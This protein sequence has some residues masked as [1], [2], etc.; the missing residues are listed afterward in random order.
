MMTIT[1]W[2]LPFAGVVTVTV[3]LLAPSPF[4][5]NA[6]TYIEYSVPGFKLA[7]VKDLNRDDL[8]LT[9]RKSSLKEELYAL[10]PLKYT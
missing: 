7:V 5:V 4:L 6:V 1:F 8:D 3:L 10:L 2:L 9:R